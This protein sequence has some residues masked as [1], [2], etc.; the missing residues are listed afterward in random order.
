MTT[1][2]AQ[3]QRQWRE[4]RLTAVPMRWGFGE[5]FGSVGELVQ[6]CGAAMLLPALVRAQQA[7]DVLAGH[8]V[9]QLL[10]PRLDRM[11]RTDPCHELGDYVAELW[12]VLRTF[13]VEAR[14]G[15]AASLCLDTLK[16]VTRQH[17]HASAPLPDEVEQ[18]GW[19]GRPVLHVLAAARERKLIDEATWGALRA[20][21]VEG[22]PSQEAGEV[23][24]MTATTV[25]W[26][27]SKGIRTLASHARELAW[28][29]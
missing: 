4:L 9:V 22:R 13:P 18:H 7:G 27:C 12:L 23:L 2:R 19:G 28:A 1:T 29:A 15:V 20:V 17:R 10:A 24:G 5:R 6:G 26:R 3:L 21:Y 8:L 11:A 14:R 25:R 16:A